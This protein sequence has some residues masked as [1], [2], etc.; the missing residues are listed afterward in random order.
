MREMI[1]ELLQ[2]TAPLFSSRLFEYGPDV[3]DQEL[4]RN[5][6]TG[7]TINLIYPL[8]FYGMD[9]STVHVS[10]F[11]K[12]FKLHDSKDLTELFSNY[13]KFLYYSWYLQSSL[14]TSFINYHIC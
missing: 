9:I 11:K 1:N 3:G 10:Y 12:I 8:R 13:L 5:L 14:D 7:K 6:D 2:I 4:P